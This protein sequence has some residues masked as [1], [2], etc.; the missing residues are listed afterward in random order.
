MRKQKKAAEKAA[1]RLRVFVF[2]LF[3][4]FFFCFC[5]IFFDT[6][7][8]SC[9]LQ[10]GHVREQEFP[11]NTKHLPL[12]SRGGLSASVFLPPPPRFIHS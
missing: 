11:H 7:V 9:F 5:S 2:V 4:F 3:F 6:V 10:E 12:F 1:K 8:T